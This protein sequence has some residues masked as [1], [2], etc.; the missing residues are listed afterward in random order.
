[1]C[2]DIFGK[3]LLI[4]SRHAFVKPAETKLIE[5]AKDKTEYQ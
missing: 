2:A 1:M 4:L 3:T 5:I